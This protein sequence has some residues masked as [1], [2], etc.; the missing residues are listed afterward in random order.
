MISIPDGTLCRLKISRARRLARLRSIAEPSFLEAVTP[1]RADGPPLA[2]TR[3]AMNR[4]PI[5][6]P[7]WYAWSKSGRRRTRLARGSDWA[8]PATSCHLPPVTGSLSA[9]RL[10]SAAFAPWRG[11]VSGRSA[12][13]SS[14]CEP[15]IR[16][17]SSGAANSA[18]TCASP[19]SAGPVH[20]MQAKLQ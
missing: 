17:P 1:S 10:P 7:F 15:G 12:R 8:V 16:A 4:P 11:A 19:S 9:R 20:G 3:R 13:S 6:T 18:G 2:T 14:T 5:R